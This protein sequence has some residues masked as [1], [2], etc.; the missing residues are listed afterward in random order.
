ME[1]RQIFKKIDAKRYSLKFTYDKKS[2]GRP[3]W[4]RIK[5][6]PEGINFISIHLGKK[7]VAGQRTQFYK[8]YLPKGL[9]IPID[10]TKEEI[11]KFYDEY[12]K[13]YDELLELQ[14]A[15]AEFLIKKVKRYILGGEMLDLG[16]GT[17]A[18]TE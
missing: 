13:D 12:S 2:K 7:G 9:F 18:I 10:Y 6:V 11:S 14:P 8:T 15:A 17:G 5:N 3:A 4:I 16:A 1:I